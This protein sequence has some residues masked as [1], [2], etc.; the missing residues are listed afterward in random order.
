MSPSPFVLSCPKVE[1][2]AHLN[3][4][5]TTKMMHKLNDQRVQRGRQ[6]VRLPEWTQNEDQV[7][8]YRQDCDLRLVF[9]LFPVVQALTDDLSQLLQITLR[10]TP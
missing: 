6:P 7:T 9:S 2:H 4:S 1:L 10:P 3:G 8:S 5:I